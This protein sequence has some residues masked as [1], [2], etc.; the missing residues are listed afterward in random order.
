M[1]SRLWIR[2]SQRDSSTFVLFLRKKLISMESLYRGVEQEAGLD[3]LC[4]APPAR[5]SVS[6][7]SWSSFE[8]LCVYEGRLPST[9]AERF[10]P[11]CALSLSALGVVA[12]LSREPPRSVLAQLFIA[13]MVFSL[14]ET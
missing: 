5:R 6:G 10:R 4:M 7:G 1:V 11:S 2:F 14:C 3:V 13:C 12:I 8:G 9:S